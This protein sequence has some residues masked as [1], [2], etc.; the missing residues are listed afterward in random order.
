MFW[1][2]MYIITSLMCV[3]FCFIATILE[4]MY[5]DTK[6]KT[7]DLPIILIM[8]VPLLNVAL[9]FR[10]CCLMIKDLFGKKINNTITAIDTKINTILKNKEEE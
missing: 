1:L 5:T 3:V 6:W 9:C 8:L 4:V 7:K 10:V 2:I